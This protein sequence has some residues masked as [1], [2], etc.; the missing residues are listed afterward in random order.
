MNGGVCLPFRSFT[1]P[2]RRDGKMEPQ[3]RR[4]LL[5][6]VS[7]SLTNRH[8]DAFTRRSQPV[9]LL[10]GQYRRSAPVDHRLYQNH[11]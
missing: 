4:I 7:R 9:R 1:F 2:L 5:R 6:A 3:F 10:H 8:F 11:C